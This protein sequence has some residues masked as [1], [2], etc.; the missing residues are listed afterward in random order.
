MATKSVT[1]CDI[2]GEICTQVFAFELQDSDQNTFRIELSR[3][4]LKQFVPAIVNALPDGAINQILSDVIGLEWQ[5][6]T[7]KAGTKT[8]VA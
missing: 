6:T 8:P 7:L 1:Y 4:G 5:K 3:N 2:T